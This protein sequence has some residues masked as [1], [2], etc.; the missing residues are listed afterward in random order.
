VPQVK[1]TK[2]T[3][4]P[5][6]GLT[7]VAPVP[8]PKKPPVVQKGTNVGA[9]NKPVAPKAPGT[10][11]KPATGMAGLFGGLGPNAYINSLYAPQEASLASQQANR[12]A[13]LQSMVTEFLNS[14]SSN[15]ASLAPY[16]NS[17][18]QQMSDANNAAAGL[19]AAN[20]NAVTQNDLAA[21]N[22][23]QAQRSQ[24]AGQNNTA[25][26]GNA[27]LLQYTG[28]V[29]P[30]DQFRD[31][32]AAR[33]SYLATL[34]ALGESL[35]LRG[36]NSIDNLASKENSDLATTKDAALQKARTDLATYV[37]G[38]QKLKAAAAKTAFDEHATT[39]RLN[40]GQSR[41]DLAS[42]VAAFNQKYKI[43]TY[44]LS[45]D[46]LNQ[47]ASKFAY[48]QFKDN[49]SYTLQLKKYGLQKASA[50]RAAIAQEYKLSNNGFT[51]L[52]VNKFKTSAYNIAQNAF[53]G[54]PSKQTGSGKTLPAVPAV[55]YQKAVKEMRS[56]GVPISMAVQALNG[57]YKPGVRGRPFDEASTPP[58]QGPGLGAR[59]NLVVQA[60]SK[61][62]GTP[63]VW[64]GNSPGKALD[65]S[66]FIQQTY[67]K[68]GIKLPRTTYAQVKQ[69][70]PVSLNQL[71]PG[72][73]VFTEPGKNGPNHV[74]LYIGNGMVQESPHTGDVNKVI[75]LQ[76]FLS[77]GFVAARRYLSGN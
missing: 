8:A 28:G 36:L 18:S 34:P 53:N 17:A 59:N 22:A 73:A 47:S 25:F 31:D 56:A 23:P 54:I 14:L 64:G 13:A 15:T 50:Q 19:A 21:I 66:A 3:P 67:S 2:V 62:L 16:T 38:N 51:P 74:G 29:I 44:N 68:L 72:D 26:G 46:R 42:Q 7:K 48:Q 58:I 5:T 41:I 24:V 65:C 32:A 77:G 11:P 60:A 57:V 37:Q 70:T 27:A 49:R 12:Q 30:S 39:T 76:S 63:Y 40:Q 71:Q 6:G 45:V 33:A 52:Q 55:S 69:G 75:P 10:A 4:K 1:A 9:G 61:M 43:S 35:G 20:P